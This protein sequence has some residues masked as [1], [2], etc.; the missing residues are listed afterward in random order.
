[1]KTLNHTQ[2]VCPVCLK[3][4]DAEVRAGHSGVFLEKS[5]PEHGFFS[6]LIWDGSAESYL[7]WD[8]GNK[9]RD[10]LVR[11]KEVSQGCPRDCGLCTE[12]VRSTCC[13]L[14]EL[15]AR[16]NLKCPV[17]FASAGETVR[18]DPTLEDIG[19]I[20]DML[21]ASGGP[22]N[23]Q[24]SGGE[25]TM[26]DDLPQIIAMGIEKGF[27]FFQLN[28][29]GLRLAEEP[30]YAAL[31]KSAG[32]SCVFL[33]FDSLSDKVYKILRGRPLL[34]KKL[35]AIQNCRDAGLG[36]V[37]V[38]VIAP[39]INDG[40]LGSILK[41]AEKNM[42]FV[43]GVHFQ[44]ISYFGRC[45]PM[46]DRRI[47]IPYMLR[48]IE[49]QTG[50]RFKISHFGGGGAENPYC[51]FH[52]TYLKGPGGGL[53]LLKGTSS[54]CC[55]TSKRSRETVARQWSGSGDS[56]PAPG[57]MDAFVKETLDNTFA[58]SGMLFQ[59]A[60]NLDLDRLKRCY[61]CETDKRYG[62]VPFCAYN[63]TSVS[64]KTLYR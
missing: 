27:S 15:T 3:T 48:S 33:Q 28:T 23:L 49:E 16:C 38:P 32:L 54:C 18:S 13:V 9:K 1:M 21:M 11:P 34:M 37:L 6:T 44:P 51:S 63:L 26:R 46:S 56:A 25:P 35:R 14:L 29:N 20:M 7:K 5:C 45:I 30:G 17:C 55:A 41:F 57:T 12:H 52:A 19:G 36:V 64:G 53:K 42:P 47:T 2:S 8:R 59:D 39:G 62:M 50:G 60:Y 43:R 58:I 24:L 4:I 31:L 61:I 22:Y 40:E 10:T